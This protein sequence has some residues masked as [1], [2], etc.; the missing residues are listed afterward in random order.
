[1]YFFNNECLVD[2]T[3]L[4]GLICIKFK[5]AI[6]KN[7]KFQWIYTNIET[8]SCN[9]LAV[10]DFKVQNSKLPE[11]VLTNKSSFRPDAYFFRNTSQFDK[12]NRRKF[13]SWNVR[14]SSST[15]ARVVRFKLSESRCVKNSFAF[16]NELS[17]YSLVTKKYKCVWQLWRGIRICEITPTKK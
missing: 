13:V 1:M 15:G 11:R 12:H 3:F 9:P 4:I 5:L 14:V 2:T 6:N 8:D 10:Y 7:F 17:I 16:V